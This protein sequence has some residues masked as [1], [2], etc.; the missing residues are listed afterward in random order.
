MPTIH[1]A[2]CLGESIRAFADLDPDNQFEESDAVNI[3]EAFSTM[4]PEV[5]YLS[6]A[7][8]LA[9]RIGLIDAGLDIEYDNIRA[10]VALSVR[11]LASLYEKQ[12]QRIKNCLPELSPLVMANMARK[13]MATVLLVIDTR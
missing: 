4:W 12:E 5:E 8:V 1:W 6:T 3:V 2:P 9:L 13:T 10:Y 7:R 11:R